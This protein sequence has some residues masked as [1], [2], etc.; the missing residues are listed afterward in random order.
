MPTDKHPLAH[1][2]SQTFVIII[3][4]GYNNNSYFLATIIEYHPAAAFLFLSY[5]LPL[6]HYHSH[7][8][9]TNNN[10]QYTVHFASFNSLLLV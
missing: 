8:L 7:G 6:H 1:S 10:T 5:L 9:L 3:V 2:Q 4:I